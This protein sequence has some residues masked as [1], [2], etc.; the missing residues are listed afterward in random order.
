M[1]FDFTPEQK[2]FQQSAEQFARDVVAPR[3]AEIDERGVFPIDVIR[4]AAS[5]GLLGVTIP[6]DRG[7]ARRGEIS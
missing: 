3:A 1:D 6:V 5:Q 2:A 7:G 4:A